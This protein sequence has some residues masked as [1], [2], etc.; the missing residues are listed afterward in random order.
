[1]SVVYDYALLK[2]PMCQKPPV[3]GFTWNRF[4]RE[5][6][7]YTSNGFTGAYNLDCDPVAFSPILTAAAPAVA[8]IP[9]GSTVVGWQFSGAAVNELFFT[10]AVPEWFRHDAFDLEFRVHWGPTTGAAAQ[11]VW[12]VD[13]ELSA[14]AGVLAGPATTI[15]IPAG[16]DVTGGV[17]D[18]HRMIAL[19]PIA[20]STFQVA[21]AASGEAT[22]LLGRLWRNPADAA[23]TYAVA[24]W[25]WRLE[26]R[27]VEV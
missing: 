16:F 23:D 5:M 15:S 25:L 19:T 9:G 26:A 22:L 12:N 13:Y 1:M 10:L 3:D 17:A 20:G 6:S 21:T 8:A 18:A 7:R 4:M 27:W 2:N 24:S 14:P 11:V